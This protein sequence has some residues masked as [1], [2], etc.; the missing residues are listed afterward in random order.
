MP[1]MSRTSKDAD[2]DRQ[3]TG[4]VKWETDCSE[5]CEDVSFNV[6]SG[7]LLSRG[8]TCPGFVK[9]DF[10]GSREP[11]QQLW[12]SRWEMMVAHTGAPSSR[13]GGKPSVWILFEG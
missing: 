2:V 9:D 13:P 10:G 11:S 1:G 8:V 4:E 5:Q 3:V 12:S 7:I 6:R